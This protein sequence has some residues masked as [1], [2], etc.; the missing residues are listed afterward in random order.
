VK[1]QPLLTEYLVEYGNLPLAETGR[2]FLKHHA[3][4]HNST[5]TML[6]GPTDTITFTSAV[7]SAAEL[8]QLANFITDRL[9]ISPEEALHLMKEEQTQIKAGKLNSSWPA[10]GN[11]QKQANGTITFAQ[12]EALG[13]YLPSLSLEKSNYQNLLETNEEPI[14]ADVVNPP[15][16]EWAETPRKDRWWIWAIV[17]FVVALALILVR[18]YAAP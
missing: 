4:S 13:K 3:A 16:Y 8:Q 10:L 11:F 15:V 18:Y 17:I 1:L 2:L 5:E 14:V 12:E 9:Q 7:P 6:V